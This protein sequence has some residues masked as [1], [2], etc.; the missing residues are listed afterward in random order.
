M[1]HD[2]LLLFAMPYYRPYATYY[3][4]SALN[5]TPNT[6]CCVLDTIYYKLYTI[7]YAL[8]LCTTDYMLYT[9]YTVHNTLCT[10]HGM[11]YTLHHM[12]YAVHFTLF[13]IA[14]SSG[15]LHRLRWKAATRSS[16]SKASTCPSA[17]AQSIRSSHRDEK[18]KASN[19]RMTRDSNIPYFK[20]LP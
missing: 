16:S 18:S 13:A 19:G 3:I 20:N 14:D 15:E 10:V 4:P 1:Q 11:P 6:I 12:L 9:I 5:Y 7:F 2:T 17:L 8:A